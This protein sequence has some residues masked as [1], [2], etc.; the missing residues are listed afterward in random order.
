MI[1]S[2]ATGCYF[3]GFYSKI[4]TVILNVRNGWIQQESNYEYSTQRSEFILN[5]Y[6]SLHSI[7]VLVHLRF[8]SHGT[9]IQVCLQGLGT[10]DKNLI[11]VI[12]TR[13]EIDLAQVSE[14]LIFK[15]STN[16]QRFTPN[17]I[18][19]TSVYLDLYGYTRKICLGYYSMILRY[20]YF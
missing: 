4:R 11:R 12:V 2:L 16:G 10:N 14:E 13:S 1:Q 5:S 9:N 7:L 6:T 3:K 17:L 19:L 8:L 18:K 20:E 15:W